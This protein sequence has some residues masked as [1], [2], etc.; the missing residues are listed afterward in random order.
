MANL[1]ELMGKLNGDKPKGEVIVN[2]PVSQKAKDGTNMG[3]RA[4]NKRHPNSGSKPKAST[5]IDRGIKAFLAEHANERIPYTFKDPVTGKERTIEKPRSIIA[6]EKLF[7]LGMGL[8]IVGNADA[9]NKWFDRNVGKPAQPLRG[10]GE[11]DAP[12]KLHVDNL[13]DIL[14]KVYGE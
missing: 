8:T 13:E 12:I 6:I 4:F 14:N 10:E 5:L 7:E 1:D 2:I 9:L 11:D 3:K